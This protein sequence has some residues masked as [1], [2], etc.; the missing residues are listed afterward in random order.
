MNCP[1]PQE[2]F[3]GWLRDALLAAMRSLRAPERHRDFLDRSTDHADLE[4]RM[5]AIERGAPSPLFW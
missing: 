4:R 2:A 5:R 3:H 1:T